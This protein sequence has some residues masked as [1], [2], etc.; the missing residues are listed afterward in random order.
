MIHFFIGL[1]YTQ[2]PEQ[3]QDENGKPKA[4]SEIL[5]QLM[6]ATGV[7]RLFNKCTIK[8]FLFR[9]AICLHKYGVIKNFFTDDKIIEVDYD[10]AK[11]EF[12]LNDLIVHIVFEINDDE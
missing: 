7:N 8:E 12:Y 10:G 6:M 1:K 3:L 5:F 2:D 9:L 4:M 11:I